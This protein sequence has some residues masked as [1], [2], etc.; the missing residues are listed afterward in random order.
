VQTDTESQRPFENLQSCL[1]S[2]CLV[3]R[4]ASSHGHSLGGSG[5]YA[6][7]FRNAHAKATVLLRALSEENSNNSAISPALLTLKKKVEQFFDL[8]DASSNRPILEEEIR[9]LLETEIFPY[10]QKP[11]HDPSDDFFPLEIVAG[12]RGYI[13][14]VAAQACGAYDQGWFDA[15]A[16]MS[17]RLLE[18]LIIE[19]YEAHGVDA[20]IKKDGSFMFLSGLIGVVLSETAFNVGRNTKSALP[21]LKELGDQSAHNRRYLAKK[22]DLDGIKRDLRIVLEEFVHLSGLKK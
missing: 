6:K 3:A 17:R 13:E 4:K 9:F 20:K 14:K 16:V 2:A 7:K 15:A 5:F 19:T 18:T 11:L 10:L 8:T 22:S 1:V 21:K 12:T